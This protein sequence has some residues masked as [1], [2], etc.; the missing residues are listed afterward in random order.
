[1]GVRVHVGSQ[2]DLKH[3]LRRFKR[4]I[5]LNRRPPRWWRQVPWYVKPG[6]ARR[7]AAHRARVGQRRAAA[8]RARGLDP[9]PP[10]WTAPPPD[11]PRRW[12]RGS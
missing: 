6:E 10:V 3:A 4:L 12:E 5:E 2:E 8:Y 9:D 7:A 11:P 1:M